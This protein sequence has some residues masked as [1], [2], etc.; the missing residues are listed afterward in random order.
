MPLVHYPAKTRLEDWARWP[1]GLLSNSV[2]G[3]P[4]VSGD[5]EQLRASHVFFYAGPSCY[6]HRAA[7]GDAV[8]YFDPATEDGKS[9]SAGPFDSGA[10]EE[11]TPKL[12]PWAQQ[13][14]RE[15]WDLL[16]QHK[17]TIANWRDRFRE[18][19]AMSYDDPDRYLD[20]SADR[21]S[22]GQ[23]DRLDPAEILEHNGSRGYATYGADCADR[24]AWT[25]E[26]RIEERV[27]YTHVRALHVPA[28]RFR[29]AQQIAD[30]MRWP[31]GFAPE[32][33]TLDPGVEATP[34]TLYAD[35]GRA[36]KEI[37]R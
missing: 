9:G 17:S 20:T 5:F 14:V 36:L 2:R 11:P 28:R 8:L 24:R 26:V 1:D 10:L 34:D 32:V 29:K 12:R 31:T 6:H 15:R 21:W 35:S 18:W 30:T 3:T 23:P 25:W 4:S 33:I 7:I 16:M 27:S 13:S 22:A 19:L 37:V